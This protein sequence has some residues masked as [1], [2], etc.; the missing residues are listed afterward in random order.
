MLY[1]LCCLFPATMPLS[2]SPTP[3]TCLSQPALT[4]NIIAWSKDGMRNTIR[5]TVPFER[6]A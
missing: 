4:V 1:N 5:G 6:C 2:G 3:A